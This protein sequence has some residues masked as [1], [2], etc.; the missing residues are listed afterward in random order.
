MVLTAYLLTL[1]F[2]QTGLSVKF[3]VPPCDK[4]TFDSDVH[5]CLSDFN[6]TME[7]SSYHDRCP[8]PTVKRDYNELKLCVD[9][10]ANKTWCKGHRFLVDEVFLGIHEKYFLLC[11]QVHDPPLTTL[12]FLIAPCIIMTFF[13]P[14]LCQK[15]TAWD[16]EMPGKLGL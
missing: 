14:L 8:W 12:I 3:I 4:N 10:S 2:I 7:T 15:L 6:N 5:I 13:L 9:N 1:I 16:I 11:G